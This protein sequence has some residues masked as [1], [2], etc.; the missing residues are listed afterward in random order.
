MSGSIAPARRDRIRPEAAAT[1]LTSTFLLAFG[2][3]TLPGTAVA[4]YTEPPPP[5]AYAL[6]NVTVVR[7]DGSRQPGLTLVIR[8]GLIQAMGTDVTVPE[9][10]RPLEGDSLFVYP[11]FVDADGAAEF[12]LPEEEVE[13][14]EVASWDPP[15]S[16]SGFMPHRRVARHLKATGSDLEDERKKGVVAAAVHPEDAM[17]PG[18][19][20]VLLFREDAEDP[21]QLVL[22]P[23]AGSVLAFESGSA[24]PGTLFGMIAFMRQAFLDANRRADVGAA[25]ASRPSGMTAPHWD[26]DYQVLRNMS[27]G[28]LTTFFRAE[29]YRDIGHALDLAGRF[30]LDLVILGGA[31][32]WR[33]APRLRNAGV[34]VLVSLDFPKA[35]RWKPEKEEEPEEEPEEEQEEEEEPGSGEAPEAEEAPTEPAARDAPEREA[36]REA[37]GEELEPEVQREKER[38]ERR[39]RNAARLAEAGVTFALTSGGGDAELREGVRKAMEYGLSEADALRAVTSTPAT[40]LGIEPVVRIRSGHAANFQVT[41]GPVFDEDTDVRY[42]F[43][44]GALQVGKEPGAEPEEPPAAN[45]TGTWEIEIETSQGTFTVTG[46]IEQEG[47][48]FEGTLSSDFGELQVEEGVVSGTDVS[49]TITVDAGGQTMQLTFNGTVEGDTISGTGSAP[50][51]SFTWEGEKTGPGTAAGSRGGRR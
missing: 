12:E 47:A 35:Q 44:D 33:V 25:Y 49:F 17:M 22:D 19:T 39:Y 32:A 45:L 43:V 1:A 38:L 42:V 14:S 46:E 11:G 18:Q 4:Q 31:E 9:D 36:Q 48:A 40:L 28:G 37:G 29:N 5:A 41:T 6:E 7:A 27:T 15:R 16:A 23:A 3:M 26:P 8:D 21:R 13:R 24:Y 2:L 50:F 51:G 30:G 34:P 20:A 10:A